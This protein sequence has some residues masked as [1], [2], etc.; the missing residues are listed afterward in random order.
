M[1]VL[2]VHLSLFMLNS[3]CKYPL[4]IPGDKKRA[5]CYRK[6]FKMSFFLRLTTILHSATLLYCSELFMH[7]SLMYYGVLPGVGFIQLAG[8]PVLT[9]ANCF[10]WN[11]VCLLE[12]TAPIPNRRRGFFLPRCPHRDHIIHIGRLYRI[13]IPRP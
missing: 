11:C 6:F 9:A 3:F 2:D 13:A 8:R 7:V 12:D 5:F 10:A 1:F 4:H